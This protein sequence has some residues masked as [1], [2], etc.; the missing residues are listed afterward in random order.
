[1][2]FGCLILMFEIFIIV[3]LVVISCVDFL[4]KPSVCQVG[5]IKSKHY[6]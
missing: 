5:A 1:M 3:L 4:L 6:P 2:M